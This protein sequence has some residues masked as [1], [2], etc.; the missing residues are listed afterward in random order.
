METVKK[1]VV[2]IPASLKDILKQWFVITK[3]MNKLRPKEI[4]VLSLLLYY[5]IMEK[6][7]FVRDEDRW[8]KV[9]DYDT[10]MHI[11]EELD[12]EDY[13]LQNILSSLRRKGAISRD[14]VVDKFYIPPID[15]DTKNFMLIFNFKVKEDEG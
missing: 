11:K 14:N 2:T 10:K 9:F 4:D 15:L 3:P 6:P 7:N 13:T 5:N 8:K 1:K 12:I